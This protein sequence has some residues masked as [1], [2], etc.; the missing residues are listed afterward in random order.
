MRIIKNK[1]FNDILAKKF[2]FKKKKEIYEYNTDIMNGEFLLSVK[3]SPPNNIK[4]VL[5][6]KETN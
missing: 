1:K 4:T 6:E 5:T 2:G 3:I